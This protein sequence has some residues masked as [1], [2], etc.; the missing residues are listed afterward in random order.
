MRIC[1][2]H[3]IMMSFVHWA[4][5]LLCKCKIFAGPGTQPIF[6]ISLPSGPVKNQ[7]NLNHLKQP[8]STESRVN[9]EID[10]PQDVAFKIVNRE[11]NVSHKWLG[12]ECTCFSLWKYISSNALKTSKLRQRRQT[13][14]K[15]WDRNITMS[16]NM[17]FRGR[18][19]V[20]H[21]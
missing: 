11:W 21:F 16:L 15:L 2:L 7:T 14:Q 5:L 4:L 1:M 6:S 3:H 13:T 19:E 17:E 20:R 9:F 12:S 18:G 10:N 8:I